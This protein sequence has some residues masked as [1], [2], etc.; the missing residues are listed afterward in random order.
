MITATYRKYLT[1]KHIHKPNPGG[2]LIMARIAPSILSADFSKLGD[3]VLR[4]EQAGADLL[5][6]DIMDGHFVPNISIGPLVVKALRPVSK[7]PFDVHLMISE[8][9]KYIP[10]FIIG[11]AD[12]ITVHAE[13]GRHLHRTVELIKSGGKKAGVALNPATSLRSI[14]SI[15]TDLDLLLIMT[16]NPGFGGQKFIPS[17]LD[18]IKNA[19]ELIDTQGYKIELEVDGGINR[20]NVSKVVEAGADI[21]VAGNAV[22]GGDGN[23][24][25]NI[26]SLKA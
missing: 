22:F 23:I 12:Y 20:E 2:L 14:E 4:A 17:M 26:R 3:H 18:K 15:L 6:I 16:V 9:D 19:R 24:E 25:D 7:L 13:T 11:G 1:S 21:F 5:H 8:P 10:D